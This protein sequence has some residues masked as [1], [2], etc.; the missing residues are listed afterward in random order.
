MIKKILGLYVALLI[1]SPTYAFAHGE[2][3]RADPAANSR[4][5]S[6]PAEVSIEFDGKLQVLGNATINIITIKDDKGQI[7]SEP[8]STV[9]GMK[10][11]SKL[12][13]LEVTD[14]IS[15]SYRIV[16]EDGHPVEGEYSFTVGET[17]VAMSAYGEETAE[18]EV[19]TAEENGGNLLVN[20][21]G[22]LILI[23]I[24]FGIVRRIK[25]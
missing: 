25:K 17:P 18:E 3:V 1:I 22:I 11:T 19:E 2:M 7:I 10:I 16:S 14:L 24:V 23:G 21:V 12:T 20:G 15:V 6:A 5:F 8:I 4:V 9:E 13:S